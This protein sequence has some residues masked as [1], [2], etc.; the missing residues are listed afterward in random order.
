MSLQQLVLGENFNHPIHDVIEYV[1]ARVGRAL[2]QVG[3]QVNAPA[4]SYKR[5][6]INYVFFSR[7]HGKF[8]DLSILFR[9]LLNFF[10]LGKMPKNYFVN[11]R[12]KPD[13]AEHRAGARYELCAP[14]IATPHC[15]G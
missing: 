6:V 9:V 14:R 15:T 5:V 10:L 8:T 3:V 2:L 7:F 4:L 12:Q 11:C 13:K 1:F